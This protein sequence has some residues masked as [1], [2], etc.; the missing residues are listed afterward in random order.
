MKYKRN[1]GGSLFAAL[2]VLGDA[3][4]AADESGLPPFRIGGVVDRENRN[5]RG[6]VMSSGSMHLPAVYTE[7]ARGYGWMTW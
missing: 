5:A 1:R 7:C 2:L 6:Q 4:A 3:G